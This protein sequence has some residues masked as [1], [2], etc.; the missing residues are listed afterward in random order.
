MTASAGS[1]F[2]ASSSSVPQ[3]TSPTFLQGLTTYVDVGIYGRDREPF[4][5]C[6]VAIH[7]DSSLLDCH[8]ESTRLPVQYAK[9]IL[10]F[11]ATQTWVREREGTLVDMKAE[12]GFRFGRDS[13]EVQ[14]LIDVD[15]GKGRGTPF[16]IG[17]AVFW[18]PRQ[19][20]IRADISGILARTLAEMVQHVLWISSAPPTLATRDTTSG[21]PWYVNPDCPCGPLEF[22]HFEEPATIR[23]SSRPKRPS[24]VAGDQVNLQVLVGQTGDICAIRP[25][26]DRGL[27]HPHEALMEAAVTA[28]K[29][30]K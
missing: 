7:R 25:G 18:V 15:H 13:S 12:L 22:I 14:L 27:P 26:R 2:A 4:V 3:M 6:S 9:D 20:A 29:Q 10:N 5:P 17:K 19:G 11:L 16:A 30:W 24:G 8:S 1:C 23:E 21:A 28:V